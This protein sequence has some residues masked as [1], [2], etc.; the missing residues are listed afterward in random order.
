[1]S[2]RSPGGHVPYHSQGP[3]GTIPYCVPEGTVLNVTSSYPYERLRTDH[4]FRLLELFPK[5]YEHPYVQ[6]LNI[7][8]SRYL[9]G[10]LSDHELSKDVSYECLSYV[11]G[12]ADTGSLIWLDTYMIEISDNLDLALRCLQHKTENRRL[13]V[14]FVCINQYDLD[15]RRQ[16]VQIMYQIFSKAKK[17]IAYLGDEADGSE[18]LPD[19]LNR[20]NDAHFADAKARHESDDLFIRPWSE[21]DR[22]RLGLSPS[23]DAVWLSLEKFISRPWF[24]RMWIIQEALAAK[25]LD[26]ICGRWLSPALDVFQIIKIAIARQLPFSGRW[27]QSYKVYQHPAACGAKQFHLMLELG[28]CGILVPDPPS[29]SKSWSLIDILERSRH[30]SCTDP[31]DY[32]FALLNLCKDEPPLHLVPDYTASVADTYINVACA[33]VKAGK[34]NK[35]LCNAFLSESVLEMPSWV[36]DWSLKGL[37]FEQL[38]PVT[39]FRDP[40]GEFKAGGFDHAIRLGTSRDNLVVVVYGV[41]FVERLGEIFEYQEDPPSTVRTT[42]DE[43]DGMPS[44]FQTEISGESTDQS[45]PSSE[46]VSP[47]MDPIQEQAKIDDDWSKFPI[48][49]RRLAEIFSCIQSSPRYMDSDHLSLVWRTMTCDREIGTQGK[50]PPEYDD[51]FRS[52]WEM[53]KC[54]HFQG[55]AFAHFMQVHRQFLESPLSDRIE[56]AE[57]LNSLV[58]RYLESQRNQAAFFQQAA[59]RFCYSMRVAITNTGFVGMVPHRTQR[60]DAIVVIKGVSVPMVLRREGDGR[61]K[62]VGQ[63]Y[64]HG[65]MD[66]EVFEMDNMEEEELI[67]I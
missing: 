8:R 48:L 15:E 66:G 43:I 67:L 37:P 20:I 26:L 17:V 6:L 51:H 39:S 19:L 4:Y 65:F 35:V 34:G 58:Q 31:R 30:A 7:D 23:G 42:D 64:F 45:E 56:S 41:D 63:A 53:M 2:Q 13:W 1:M 10:T 12:T 25:E 36:P 44:G 49:F 60:G 29:L 18:S 62:V 28:L 33:L 24:V 61:F 32:V 52:Y 5:S 50:A 27:S 38:S 16:Q 47:A 46:T 57:Q 9:Y 59:Q 14:D 11:C 3:P 22:I 21:E 54:S 40:N 55:E